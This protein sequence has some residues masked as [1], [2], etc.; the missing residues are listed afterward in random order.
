VIC[1]GAGKDRLKG[2]KGKNTLL[3]P[4]GQRTSAWGGKRPDTAT[5]S[6]EVEKSI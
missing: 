1:G 4:E 6:C 5:K 2:G 3:G